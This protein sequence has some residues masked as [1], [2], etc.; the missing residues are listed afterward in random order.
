[1]SQDELLPLVEAGIVAREEDPVPRRY[2]GE[3]LERIRRGDEPNASW[4]PTGVPSLMSV[5]TVGR[6]L[7]EEDLRESR[8]EDNI[9]Q[10]RADH[11]ETGH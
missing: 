2:L 9:E 5:A 11:A 6:R 7:Y 10:A 1:M 3:A 8:T 4:Y